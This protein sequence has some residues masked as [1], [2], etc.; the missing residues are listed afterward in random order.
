MVKTAADKSREASLHDWNKSLGLWRACDK[1][2]CRRARACRGDVRACAPKNFA[3]APE[4]VQAWFCCLMD[5]KKEGLSF[6]EAMA[7]LKDTPAEE[8]FTLWHAG[9][10]AVARSVQPGDWKNV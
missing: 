5:C 10:E 9:D 4:G 6:D 7:Q 2:A 8:A 1:A 3:A